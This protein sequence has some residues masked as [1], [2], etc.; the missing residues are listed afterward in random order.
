M[1]YEERLVNISATASADLSAQQY[2]FV[3]LANQSGRVQAQRA[4]VGDRVMGILQ[5]NPVA[6]DTATVAIG[7]VSK[8]VAGG[9]ILAGASVTSD[10][11]GR[12]TSTLTG[13]DFRAGVAQEAAVVGQIFAVLLFPIGTA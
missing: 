8:C 5:N 3:A 10:A 9:T 7:G 4:V 12:A 2:R 13:T 1:S 6:G 11:Q